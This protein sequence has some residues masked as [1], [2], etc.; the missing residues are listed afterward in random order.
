VIRRAL[1]QFGEDIGAVHR[2]LIAPGRNQYGPGF[3]DFYADWRGEIAR[4]YIAHLWRK[5][6]SWRS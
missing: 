5:L 1:Q 3:F 4:A 6:R 2:W